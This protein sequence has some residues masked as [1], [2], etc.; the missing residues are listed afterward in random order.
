MK[1]RYGISDFVELKT[2][3]YIA[4]EF[5]FELS[6]STKHH[7][8]TTILYFAL[9]EFLLSL[10]ELNLQYINGSVCEFYMRFMILRMAIKKSTSS[11]K[12]RKLVP[13]IVCCENNQNQVMEPF[14]SM[15][16][17]AECNET[18]CSIHAKHGWVRNTLQRRI[19]Q[20]S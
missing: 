10:S 6:T 14:I 19:C 1:D 12:S 9:L 16:I 18:T 8:S 2:T 3:Q 13:N 17:D 20:K 4:V 7:F 11:E 5:L 15:K